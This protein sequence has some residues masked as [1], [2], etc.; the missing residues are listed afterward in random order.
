M[1]EIVIIVPTMIDAR[2]LQKKLKVKIFSIQSQQFRGHS[3]DVLIIDEKAL[4]SNSELDIQQ[5]IPMTYPKNGKII[6]T[7]IE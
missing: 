3:A 2:L 1:F 5:F 7:E 4:R 6:V